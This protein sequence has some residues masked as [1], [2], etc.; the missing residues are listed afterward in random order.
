MR[1]ARQQ[2]NSLNPSAQAF[3]AVVRVQYGSRA[4]DTR[5]LRIVLNSSTKVGRMLL[6]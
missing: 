6:L 1:A 2:S 5:P 3:G 4:H